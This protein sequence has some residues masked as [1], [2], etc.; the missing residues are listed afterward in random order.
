[1]DDTTQA[2][3]RLLRYDIMFFMFEY[4]PTIGFHG[5]GTGHWALS[6]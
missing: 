5:I 1:M 2:V 3:W 4:M 6:E